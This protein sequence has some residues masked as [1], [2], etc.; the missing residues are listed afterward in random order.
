MQHVQLSGISI[1]EATVMPWAYDETKPEGPERWVEI[2]DEPTPP[3]ALT[4]GQ[5]DHSDPDQFRGEDADPPVMPG[6]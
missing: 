2:V 4:A 3:L 5:E 1:K 6:G